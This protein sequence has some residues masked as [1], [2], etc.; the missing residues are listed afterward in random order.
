MAVLNKIRQR[1]LFLIIVIA[2]ALFSFVLADLFKNSGALTS[3][4]QN[5]IATI[6]GVDISRE[7]FTPG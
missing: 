6:N 2:L 7:D 5:I 4:S 3:K 1:S